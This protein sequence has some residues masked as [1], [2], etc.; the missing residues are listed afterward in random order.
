MVTKEELKRQVCEAIERRADAL[1]D[2]GETIRHQPELGFKEFKTAALVAKTFREI[3]VPHRTELA[4]TGVKAE[5]RGAK[6]GPSVALLGE[7]DAL[8][9][10]AHPL[11][12]PTTGAAHA[13]GHNAQITAVLGATMALVDTGAM[14]HLAGRLVPFAVPAEEYGDIAWRLEQVRAG[15]LEFLGGKPE[16]IRH[17][18][19]DDVDMALLIHTTSRSEDRGAG[20]S[21]SN[22]GCVVKSIRY[23]GRAAHARRQRRSPGQIGPGVPCSPGA[24]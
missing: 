23:V 5:L 18:H 7:L 15:R 12:D 10:S 20:V 14:K 9:V 4:I 3:D 16:L 24:R 19:F 13:C 2:L 6:P 17:G 21:A 8:V 22:N 1:I 11:A